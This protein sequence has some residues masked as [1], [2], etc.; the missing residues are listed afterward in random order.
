MGIIDYMPP[1]PE[2]NARIEASIKDLIEWRDYI[3]AKMRENSLIDFTKLV[4][5]DRTKTPL[6]NSRAVKNI[7]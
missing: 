4:N 2:D 7:A 5:Y 1:P 6:Y 3:L